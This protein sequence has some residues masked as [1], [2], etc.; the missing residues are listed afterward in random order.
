MI[1]LITRNPELVEKK[2]PPKITNNK[3]IKVKFSGISLS[4]IPIFETLLEIATSI[5]KKLLSMLKKIKKINI[6]NIK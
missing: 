2:E 4:E 3:K 6:I 5:D 1:T